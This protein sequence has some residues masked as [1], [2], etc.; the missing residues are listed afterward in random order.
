MKRIAVIGTGY[1]GLVAGAGLSDFGNEVTCSDVNSGRIADLRSGKIPFY[2][3]GLAELVRK[4]VAAGR[5]S[6]TTDVG[7]AVLDSE[8]VL[9]AV[10]TPEGK[11]GEADL[12]AVRDVAKTIGKNLNG[13]KV[14]CTK[15]TVPIGTGEMV[16]RI[17]KDTSPEDH[18]FDIVSNPEFL[19]EGAAVKDF[20]IPNRVVIGSDSQRALETMREVYR[21]LFINET[22]MVISDII[23]AE[24]IKYACNAFLAVKIS[25][26]NEMANLCDATG[27]DVH[28]VAKA[29]GLDGRISPKFLHPGPGF[30]GSCFPKDTLALVHQGESRGV[31][32]NVV[33]AAIRANEAQRGRVVEKVERLVGKDLKGKTVA[34]LGLAFKANTDDVRQSPA[35]PIIDH[36]LEGGARV[37]AFDPA[38]AANMRSVFPQ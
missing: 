30:G 37:R 26:I 23:T 17:I 13:Y 9:I 38:A 25:Y 12:S 21:P 22:P 18:E 1:V 27:A 6:F 10:W 33:G 11:D 14:I 29:M 4:N 36:L 34:I 16:R 28:V 19:R 32:L 5:L 2:E 3:P 7:G 35:I 15:S 20:L 8:V 31:E 24:T